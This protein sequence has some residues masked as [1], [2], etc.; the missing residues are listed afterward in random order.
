MVDNQLSF[1]RKIQSFFFFFVCCLLISSFC[2][3][4]FVFLFFLRKRNPTDNTATRVTSDYEITESKSPIS[5]L[6]VSTEVIAILQADNNSMKRN[7]SGHSY[8]NRAPIHNRHRYNHKNTINNN[9]NLR[10]PQS[11]SID[12][13]VHVIDDT[14]A[15][16]WQGQI[17]PDEIKKD[18]DGRTLFSFTASDTVI[19]HVSSVCDA[20]IIND[21][22]IAILGI[23]EYL[24]LR[25]LAGVKKD[26][27]NIINTFVKYWKYKVLYAITDNGKSSSNTQF[28]YTN[29]RTVTDKNQNYKL[30]WTLDDIDQFVEQAR[31]HVVKN[32]HNGMIFV[33][34]SHGDTDKIIYD[35]NCEKKHLEGIFKLFSPQWGQLLTS[36]K[37][38]EDESKHLFQIP[39][40]FCIDSCRG[41]AIAKLTK[42][43]TKS[44]SND[45]INTNND[46]NQ[47]NLEAKKSKDEQTIVNTQVTNDHHNSTKA[48]TKVVGDETFGLKT[49][50]KD[51]AKVYSA[52]EGNFCKVWANTNGF[53][54]GGSIKGGIF[55][56]SVAYVFKD[57]TFV[58]RHQWN[59][60]IIKIREKTKQEA[61]VVGELY[62][63]TQIVEDESTLERPIQFLRFGAQPK[64]QST[65]ATT[66]VSSRRQN[67]TNTGS[68]CEE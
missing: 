68:G 58:D 30:F 31:K 25:N 2:F 46:T 32:K 55:L 7:D 66:V 4:F 37:E 19:S 39:K 38:T 43:I 41:D 62:N 49:I 28:V 42:V 23:G 47:V 36:Y 27:E 65:T 59:D 26:Y 60:I 51:A 40:I 12:M 29:D 64:L 34:S 44:K 63:L 6:S 13:S 50:S 11:F 15:A 24:G 57:I 14:V 33:I 54:V 1:I 10:N 9:S 53:A 3:F 8:S 18:N 16:A 21:V 5:P 35:S 48:V 56:R 61:S 52:Q 22:L 20:F 67:V 45:N 17:E